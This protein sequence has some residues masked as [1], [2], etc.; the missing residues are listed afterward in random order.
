M[1]IL[2]FFKRDK[3]TSKKKF[4]QRNF[5]SAKYDNLFHGWRGTDL[6]ADQE[7]INNLQVIRNRV[8]QVCNDDVYARRF[9]SM[10]K[11]NVIGSDGIILQSKAKRDDG[12]FDTV[13]IQTIET[14]WKKWGDEKRFASADRRLNWLDIQR[15]VI[16]TLARDGEVFIRMVRTPNNPFNFSLFIMEG[17]WF[18]LKKNEFLNENRV[19]RM[20]IEQNGFGEPVAYHQLQYQPNNNYVTDPFTK[21]T[22]RVSPD[23]IIH[24]YIMERPGQS[25]GIPWMNTA[26]RGLEMLHQYHES[27]LVASRIGSSA[28]GFF[29]S[30]DSQGYTG[31]DKDESGNIITEF[32]PGTFQQLPD[33]VKFEPFTPNHPTNAFPTFVKSILRSISSGLG[34]SYNALSSDLESVNFS[35]IRAGVMEERVVWQTL[36]NFM[37][38]NFCRPVFNNWLR[39]A[40][41]SGELNLPMQKIDKFENVSWVPRGWSYVD[42]LK[43]INAHKVAH[44]M[45]VESLTDIASSK[46]KDL[47]EIFEKI[48]RENELAEQ[49]GISLPQKEDAVTIAVDE[50]P[51][52]EI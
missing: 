7:L 48:K 44:E 16:E 17:D 20:S 50:E 15:L 14:A 40:I 27:E 30:Q 47:Q 18:D 22:E 42:P 46:G 28:M 39:M 41:A 1:K 11:S 23:E 52:A 13:D 9:L 31:V 2:D 51:D 29:T 12:T 35:S 25:R 6:S 8:R 10:T 4:F 5:A 3:P 45:G 24:L 43:E 38:N 33:G 37:V 49:L 21:P 32:Q 36:Q 19:I 34:V 26:L